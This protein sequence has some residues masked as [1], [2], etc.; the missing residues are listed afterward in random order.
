MNEQDKETTAEDLATEK[1]DYVVFCFVENKNIA[2]GAY[3]SMEIFASKH[4]RD[5]SH[6][7]EVRTA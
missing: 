2:R 5:T 4:R 3:A 1:D 7:C 6:G